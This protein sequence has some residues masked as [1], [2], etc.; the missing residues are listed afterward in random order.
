MTTRDLLEYYANLLILQFKQKPKA[1]ATIEAVARPV[2][3]A[4]VS[5]FEIAFPVI[6]TSGQFSISYNG[7]ASM[8]ITWNTSTASVQAILRGV[9]G[10]GSVVVTGSIASGSL[11]VSMVGVEAPS[12]PLILVTTTLMR[13]GS[14]VVPSVDETDVTMPIAVQNA[15]NLNAALGPVAIG[16][17][18]DVLAKYVG[19]VREAFGI[20]GF[21]TLDDADF[22]KLM[23][24][25]IIKNF[26]DSDLS[27]I[28]DLLVEFFPDTIYVFDHE[29]MRLSYLIDSNG[30]DQD[31]V[32]M[33]VAQGLLP[34]PMAVG[35]AVIYHDGVLNFFGFGNYEYTAVANEPFNT[36]DSY[37][38]T[39][40]WMS[41]N[42]AVANVSTVPYFLELETGGFLL[43]EGG[44]MIEI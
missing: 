15:F 25:A 30:A 38:Q 34:K 26:L 44:G 9:A 20:T 29:D 8:L 31:L 24:I 43:T 21:I 32:Q 3:M 14:L 37:N 16:A 13:S 27:D 35:L 12:L 1:F 41:Y 10:L 39:W 33:F 42:N 36:Y 22:L 23:Q 40:P 18:L 2:I 19:V 7:L 28:V 11:I 4:Q 5:A 6:P 17:Q